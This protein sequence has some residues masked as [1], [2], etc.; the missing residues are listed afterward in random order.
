[1]TTP[2]AFASRCG[3]ETVLS[4]LTLVCHF[5]RFTHRVWAYFRARLAFTMPGLQCVG[6]TW[7]RQIFRRAGE[8]VGNGAAAEN[9]V[10]FSE[11]PKPASVPTT[12]FVVE[13][14]LHS[15]GP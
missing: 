11:V 10:V 4:M 1:M 9:A 13:I 5:K 6:L 8:E 3:L 7:W 2:A 14:V 15:V 12:P